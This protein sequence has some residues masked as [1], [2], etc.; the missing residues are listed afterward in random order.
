MKYLILKD[1]E[2]ADDDDPFSEMVGAGGNDAGLPFEFTTEKMSER[3]AA[4]RRREPGVKEV[5]PSIPVTLVKPV[6]LPPPP[7]QVAP[8][9]T[10]GVEAVGAAASPYD[11]AGVCVAILD[12]GIDRDHAAFAGVAFDDSDLRDFT[13]EEKGVPGSAPDFD[14]HG[15]HVAGTAF[16]RDVG[17]T[18]IGVARGVKKVLI[19]KVLGR[20]TTTESVLNGIQ[21]ALRRRADVISLSLDFDFTTVVAQ[22]EANDFPKKIALSRALEA[23]RATVR[24][25]DRLAARVAARV[26]RGRG[27]LLVAASGNAS[28]RDLNVTFTVATAPPA[29]ADGFV[30]VGAV[31]RNAD[32]SY[33]V[34]DFSN[35]SCRLAA[36]G[37]GILSAQLGEGLTIKNGTSMATPHVAGVLALWTQK[38]FPDG[39]RPD[40]WAK[41]V[42]RAVEGAV[43]PLPGQAREDVG[44]GLVRA[45]Q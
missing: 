28:R 10:W 15:T 32:A 39:S 34:A 29:V 17:G 6:E 38:L 40:G 45:P 4:Q 1:R 5:I 37:V 18:R 8:P 27:A 30:S 44:I 13:V 3:E 36:P 25:F 31:R 19:G 41:D 2:D 26:A 43:I 24:L 23:Y 16:G 35:T 21:W 22:F 9:T 7:D 42:M 14:G 11:G 20:L 12:T 33:A